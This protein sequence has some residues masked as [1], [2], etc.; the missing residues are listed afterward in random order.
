M[1]NG[2]MAYSIIQ[3]VTFQFSCFLYILSPLYS[4]M[5]LLYITF[6]YSSFISLIVLLDADVL[7]ILL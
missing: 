2:I 4:K 1:I 3:F 7:F 5:V 6:F